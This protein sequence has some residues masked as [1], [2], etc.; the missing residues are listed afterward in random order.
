MRLH[1]HL[2][3]VLGHFVFL[4][5]W[6]AW[7]LDQNAGSPV[8]LDDVDLEHGG[9]VIGRENATALVFLDHVALDEAFGLNQDY[10]VM[11]SDNLILLN[12][13]T[14][15]AFNHENSFASKSKTRFIY[16]SQKNL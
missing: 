10:A 2:V 16:E 11:I 5:L 1:L 4:H 6:E 12:I 9:G 7:V 8:L 13:D 15:L 3:V 14:I